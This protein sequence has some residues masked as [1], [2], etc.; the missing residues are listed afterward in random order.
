MSWILG[1]Y[2]SWG[3]YENQFQRYNYSWKGF[4]FCHSIKSIFCITSNKNNNKNKN[5]KQKVD[6]LNYQLHSNTVKPFLDNFKADGG[7]LPSLCHHG[8]GIG[9]A[10]IYIEC[11]PN[12]GQSV[13]NFKMRL[14]LETIW[15]L[16]FLL[17][18][19]VNQQ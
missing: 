13:S 12:E 4:P 2:F 15:S 3:V 14:L 17:F 16:M 19:I 10:Y 11:T 7:W 5:K 18:L 1:S 6:L 8:G 9:T